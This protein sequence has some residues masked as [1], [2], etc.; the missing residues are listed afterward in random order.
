MNLV[1]ESEL[2]SRITGAKAAE[3]VSSALLAV[4]RSLTTEERTK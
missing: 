2:P 3:S 1:S 4:Q